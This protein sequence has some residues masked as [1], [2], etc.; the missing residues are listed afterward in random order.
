[1][2]QNTT[3]LLSG[4][5]SDP[6]GAVIPGATVVLK[7][8]QSGDERRTITN[9]DGFFSISGVQVGDYTINITAQGFEKYK[10]TDIHFDAGDTRKLPSHQ[11][12]SWRIDRNCHG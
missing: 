10:Q 11:S 8:Q 2:A 9:N 7:N 12:Q 5:V 3:G 1:M 4:A 6:S